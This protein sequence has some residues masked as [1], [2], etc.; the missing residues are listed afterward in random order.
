MSLH[1]QMEQTGTAPLI[2]SKIDQ[3]WIRGLIEMLQHIEVGQLS[4]VLPDGSHQAITGQTN[5]DLKATLE[6][7]NPA[8]ARKFIL[9]GT[10]GFAESY[11]AGDWDSPDLTSLLEIGARSNNDL[12]PRIQGNALFRLFKFVQHNFR[13]N[14]KRGSR[15]NISYHYDLGN[16][17]YAAWLDPSMTYSSALFTNPEQS[18][19][20]AQMVKFR[21]LANMLDLKPEHHVLEIGCGWGSFATFVAREYGC[22][23]TGLTLSK[24]QLAYARNNARQTGLEN[25]LEFRLQDYRDLQGTFDR[26]AS[27]EMFEAVGKENWPVYFDVIKS[28]LKPNGRMAL[29]TIVINDQHFQ[30]YCQKADFI[31]SYIFPG[32][33]LPSPSSFNLEVEKAG[34]QQCDSVMF[35]ESYA[36]TLSIWQEKFQSAWPKLKRLGFDQRFKRMWEFYLAY[37]EAGFRAG[38][39][40]VGIYK[41]SHQ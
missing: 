12:S 24:E 15:K 40:D 7:N 20:D 10:I 3:I 28:H 32:G 16:D 26:I 6:I 14:T 18:L 8:V 13:A 25:L 34:L 17:F 30:E 37:C 9:G 11:M 23:V 41:L 5:H 1:Q 35:G 33:M 36:K 31:Q 38:T 29:Q 27:I 22:R 39:I 21:Q 4:I 19:T 2:P